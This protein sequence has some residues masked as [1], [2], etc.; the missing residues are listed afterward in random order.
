MDG[1]ELK[2]EH[3][4]L[5][6]TWNISRARGS[7]EI[8][9][10]DSETDVTFHDFMIVD[11][12]P[13]DRDPRVYAAKVLDFPEHEDI[14]NGGANIDWLFRTS[15]KIK[16]GRRILGMCY[17][18]PK[19]QGDLSPLFD[20]LLTRLLG[21]IPDFLIVLDLAYWNEAS[22]LQ[23]EILVHHE[24]LHAAQAKDLFGAPKFDRDGNPVWALR[25]HDLE[26]FH[27]V[28]RRY[29]VHSEDVEA[30]LHAVTENM[31]A[32]AP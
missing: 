18:K 19:V 28:V 23:R 7:A 14:S 1:L 9:D 17:A 12:Q 32:A 4:Q 20:D 26:E 8:V 6:A 22:P 11:G 30:F 13:N 16:A 5:S 2:N 25:A 3:A 10:A 27:D 21:R 29:G 15:E 24:L 31:E